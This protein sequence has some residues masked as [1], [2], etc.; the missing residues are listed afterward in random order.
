MGEIK[1]S[2]YDFSLVIPAF[3]EEENVCDLMEEIQEAFR[4]ANIKGQVIF[5]DDGSTDNTFK[6]AVAYKEKMN[7]LK[8]LR[9]RRNLGKTE[10][11]MTGV[12]AS[13]SPVIIILDADLQ[14]SPM[15][16]PRFLE[17]IDEG[18]DIVTGRKVGNYQKRIVSQIYNRLSQKLFGQGVSLRMKTVAFNLKN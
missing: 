1:K 12:Q 3:D 10:A 7:Y 2:L 11:I 14:Y 9:H 4:K 17:K 15:E 13:E 16:I 5:V 18:Y 6:Q 8:V